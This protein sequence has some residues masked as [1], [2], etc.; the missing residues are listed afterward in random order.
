LPITDVF[1]KQLA[2]KHK[3]HYKVCRSC[4]A[5]NALAASMCR[6]CRGHNLRLKK[7]ELGAK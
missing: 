3:L 2:Q 6:K 5:R 1:K 7:R 4:G